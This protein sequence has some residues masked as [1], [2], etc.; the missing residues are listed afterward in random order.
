MVLNRRPPAEP[1]RPLYQE[2]STSSKRKGHRYEIH[3]N[4]LHIAGMPAF[5]CRLQRPAPRGA[6]RLG[7][8]GQKDG[9]RVHRMQRFGGQA[10]HGRGRILRGGRHAVLS[11]PV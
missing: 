1:Q 8:C 4:T 5:A 10:D 6:R 7:L 11:D 2:R 3:K 9:H